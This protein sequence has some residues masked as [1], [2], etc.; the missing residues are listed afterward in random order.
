MLYTTQMLLVNF[1]EKNGQAGSV[2]YPEAATAFPTIS[3]AGRRTRST[4]GRA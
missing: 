4:S 2:L 1:P 3:K